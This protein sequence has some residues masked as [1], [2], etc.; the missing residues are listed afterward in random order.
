MLIPHMGKPSQY[1][2]KRFANHKLK[3]YREVTIGMN[4]LIRFEGQ[5]KTIANFE[6][7]G[8]LSKAVL[9]GR[10]ATPFQ[11]Q[12]LGMGCTVTLFQK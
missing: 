3:W 9:L 5:A 4:L 7:E 6:Y 8:S 10:I 11:K 12:T 1:H 2:K